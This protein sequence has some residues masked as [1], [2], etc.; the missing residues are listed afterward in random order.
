MPLEMPLGLSAG[1]WRRVDDGRGWR[2]A[3]QRGLAAMAYVALAMDRAG[4]GGE[5]LAPPMCDR[6]K[7]A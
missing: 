5:E 6:L 7:A 3:C 2:V 4:R 1:A